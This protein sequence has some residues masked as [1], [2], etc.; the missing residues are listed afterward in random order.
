MLRNDQVV[1]FY[2]N[3]Q[4]ELSQLY[5][6]W[7]ALKAERKFWEADQVKHEINLLKRKVKS[8]PKN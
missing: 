7:K 5:P 3:P 2:K 6:K 8:W 1:T 4:Q